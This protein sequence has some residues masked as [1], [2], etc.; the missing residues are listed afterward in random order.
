MLVTVVLINVIQVGSLIKDPRYKKRTAE[1]L[2]KASDCR[3]NALGLICFVI[4]AEQSGSVIPEAP[5]LRVV[6]TFSGTYLYF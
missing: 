1:R 5:S 4:K 2:I 6:F 3:S